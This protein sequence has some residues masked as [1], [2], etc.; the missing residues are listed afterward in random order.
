MPEVAPPERSMKRPDIIDVAN[1]ID[2]HDREA[3]RS[4]GDQP[5]RVI[6]KS[7]DIDEEDRRENFHL[8][9]LRNEKPSNKIPEEIQCA[10]GEDGIRPFLVQR[11]EDAVSSNT[12]SLYYFSPIQTEKNGVA[13]KGEDGDPQ[14]Q[15]TKDVPP[16]RKHQEVENISCITEN[17][18]ARKLTFGELPWKQIEQL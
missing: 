9:L 17:D 10:F 3:I 16:P 5:M 7:H 6:Q 2:Y 15:V 14:I 12:N 8:H 1:P 4:N 13:D 18:R 11:S